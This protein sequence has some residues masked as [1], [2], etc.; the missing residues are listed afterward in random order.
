MLIEHVEE[1]L[2]ENIIFQHDNAS[3][4][5]SKQKKAWI[6]ENNIGVMYW[7]VCSPNPNSIEN[8]WDLLAS[9]VYK[10]GRQFRSHG[11]K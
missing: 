11:E 7:P 3:I 4:L 6:A 2:E 8:L 9:E 5:E 1:N 10:H